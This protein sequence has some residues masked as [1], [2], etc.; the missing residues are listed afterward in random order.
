MTY[1]V[2]F[3]KTAAEELAG[4]PRTAQRQIMKRVD[5]L[6]AGPRPSGVEQLKGAEKFLGSAWGTI[7]SSTR[8]EA[9]QIVVLIVRIAHRKAVYENLKVL[10]SR[11]SGW[12]QRKK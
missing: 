12:R 5:G 3:L 1:T 2:E 6:Q 9:R 11:V 4:L 7:A 8:V 10:A